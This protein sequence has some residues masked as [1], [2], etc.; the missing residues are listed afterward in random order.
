M[1]TF[2]ST[3]MLSSGSRGSCDQ[4]LGGAWTVA[5]SASCKAHLRKARHAVA[6]RIEDADIMEANR[7]KGLPIA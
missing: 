7:A 6:A 3:S 4:L 2:S 1:I 5:L